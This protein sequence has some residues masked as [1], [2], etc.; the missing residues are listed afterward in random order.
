VAESDYFD[1]RMGE[2]KLMGMFICYSLC[3]GTFIWHRFTLYNEMFR[4]SSLFLK[5]F[6]KSVLNYI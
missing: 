4:M 2:V 3:H 5:M 6:F 1:G